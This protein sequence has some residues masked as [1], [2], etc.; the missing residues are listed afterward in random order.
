MSLTAA[1]ALVSGWRV[2]GIVGMVLLRS[3]PSARHAVM[4]CG[5]N[6]LRRGVGDD[7]SVSAARSRAC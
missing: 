6:L 1:T 4:G 3:V 5:A 2:L 7:S